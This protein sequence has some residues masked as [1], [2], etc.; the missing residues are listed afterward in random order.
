MKGMDCAGVKEA[1]LGR[2]MDLRRETDT[3]RSLSSMGVRRE[4]IPELACNAMED[5]CMAT[6]PR[7]PDLKDI[8]AI[9]EN[10][11]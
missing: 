3:D 6:N 5:A 9:F 2:I 1:V 8:E 4:D 10:A 7:R 11:L